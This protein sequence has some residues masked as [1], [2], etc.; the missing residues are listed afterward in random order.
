MALALVASHCHE[1]SMWQVT[2]GF[3]EFDV[4]GNPFDRNDVWKAVVSYACKVS[5]LVK[6]NKKYLLVD[7]LEK[8]KDEPSSDE[9][10]EDA[11]RTISE[12]ADPSEDATTDAT[13]D[14]P[15][16]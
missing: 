2:K 4:E 1:V 14:P 16:E 15:V 3:P 8:P 10:V 9:E 5:C 6:R 11:K 12:Q 7:D 13:S